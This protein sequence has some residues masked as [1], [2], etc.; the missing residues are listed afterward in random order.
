MKMQGKILLIDREKEIEK[1]RYE[2]RE[3]DAER[4][5]KIDRHTD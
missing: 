5:R 4:D 3:R 2:E 1:G